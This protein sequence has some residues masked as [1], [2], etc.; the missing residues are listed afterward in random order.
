MK[1]DC[2]ALKAKTTHSD[3][4]SSLDYIVLTEYLI[5]KDD[6]AA[7]EA[8]ITAN[9]PKGPYAITPYARHNSPQ[10]KHAIDGRRI[11]ATIGRFRQRV[12]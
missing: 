7:T 1:C 8:F 12:K 6:I 2:G 10:D 4:C 11:A 5:D 9:P 3:W